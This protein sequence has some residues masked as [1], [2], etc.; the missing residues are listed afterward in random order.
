[1]YRKLKQYVHSQQNGWIYKLRV[2]HGRI[3]DWLL[4]HKCYWRA[5]LTPK[6]NTVVATAFTGK[7]YGDNPGYIIEKIH[8]LSPG[9][10]FVWICDDTADAHIPAFIH[11]VSYQEQDE[12]LKYLAKAMVIIDNNWCFRN[13]TR[14]EDQLHIQ[15]WHGGLG[16]KKIGA[17]S[18]SHISPKKMKTGAAALNRIYDFCISNSDFLTKVY[19]SAYG[20]DGLVWKCG[21][22]IEDAVLTGNNERLECRNRYRIPEGTRIVLYAPTFRTVYRW[23]SKLHV[24]RV[25]N[26]FQK[27]FGGDWVLLVHWHQE[28]CSE[29]RI[30][31]GAIDVTGT[32]SMQELVKAADACITD[33]S[34]S[35][36]QA[37]LRQIPCFVYAD[38]FEEYNMDRGMY[39]TF[40]EQPF[41]YALTN[42]ELIDN[43]LNYD[44]AVWNEKWKQYQIRMGHIV[45][46]HSAED[47]AKVCVDFLNGKPK[48]E[49][50]KEIPFETQY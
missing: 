16:F 41:P 29:D 39:L 24:S 33:Y 31:P 19:R 48:A 4:M 5:K 34:S 46:G 21:Y 17:D 9:T 36:F 45:T 44:S 35:I 43:I 14:Q 25:V 20:Y 23:Q 50:M 22:P 47:I 28:M 12:I 32:S 18:A 15:T 11:S 38:D 6:S 2:L 13:Q 8:E 7:M 37:V 27:R 30:L 49:I 40:D 3:Y 10:E 1:M 42:E 26:A